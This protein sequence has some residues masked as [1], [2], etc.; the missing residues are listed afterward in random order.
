MLQGQDH[1]RRVEG[2][3]GASRMV[4]PEGVGARLHHLIE[5]AANGCLQQKIYELLVLERPEQADDEGAVHHKHK[6]PL[7]TDVLLHFG[8]LDESLRDLLQGVQHI[9]RI[10]LV[11]YEGDGTEGSAAQEADPPQVLELHW[12]PGRG[13]GPQHHAGV[14]RAGAGLFDIVVPA[15]K[16]LVQDVSDELAVEIQTNSTQRTRPDRGQGN[17]LLQAGS[18]QQ[19]PLTEAMP[20][21]QLLGHLPIDCPRQLA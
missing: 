8:F 12:A 20:P 14:I 16:C 17:G 4:A 9:P 19:R 21:A 15:E 7:P 18:C 6:V 1:A 2:G 10:V 13:N 11:V 5:V 3:A